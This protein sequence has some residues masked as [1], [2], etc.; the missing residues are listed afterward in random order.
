MT[1]TDSH[2]LDLFDQ[3]PPTTIDSRPLDLSSHMISPPTIVDYHPLNC[4]LDCPAYSIVP[5]HCQQLFLWL[6]VISFPY[7][8]KKEKKIKFKKGVV[9]SLIILVMA[10]DFLIS[11]SSCVLIL[12]TIFLQDQGWVIS[13]KRVQCKTSIIIKRVIFVLHIKVHIKETP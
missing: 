1:T 8:P 5:N 9:L 2:P 13:R 4:P 10:P 12:R 11:T 7:S 6:L 3:T